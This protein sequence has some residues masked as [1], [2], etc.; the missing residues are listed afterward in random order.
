LHRLSRIE[1]QATGLTSEMRD[2]VVAAITAEA[3]RKIS[4]DFES[5]LQKRYA[6]AADAIGRASQVRATANH[7]LERLQTEVRALMRRGNLNLVLGTLTTGA[8]ATILAYVALTAKLA[9]G[10]WRSYMPTYL[11]RLSV[12]VFIEIFAFFFLRLYRASLADIKY[13]QNEITNLEAKCLALEFTIL[14]ADQKAA[15]K[16]A[17]ELARTERNFVLKKDQTTVE[18][19]KSRLESQHLQEALA[20][21]RAFVPS[22]K[23]KAG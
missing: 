3:A 15:N 14:S 22:K 20:T 18:L 8:A 6:P 7:M 1:E 12:V 2:S 4:K 10:D 23:G 9:G 19:E 5:E 21:I 16:V 13:F 17:E 11:L